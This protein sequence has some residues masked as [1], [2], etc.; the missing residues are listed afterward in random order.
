MKAANSPRSGST[1]PQPPNGDSNNEDSTLYQ[2]SSLAPPPAP[3]TRRNKTPNGE[4]I[5]PPRTK[6]GYENVEPR[7]TS[8][9]KPP[10]KSPPVARKPI[11]KRTVSSGMEASSSQSEDGLYENLKSGPPKPSPGAPPVPIPRRQVSNTLEPLEGSGGGNKR[12]SVSPPVPR[13]P[14]Q[15]AERASTPTNRPLPPE[16]PPK[17]PPEVPSREKTPRTTPD[18]SNRSSS[19]SNNN[20]EPPSD[21]LYSTV[22]VTQITDT[23]PDIMVVSGESGKKAPLEKVEK[24]LEKYNPPDKQQQLLNSS[25]NSKTSIAELVSLSNLL[26]LI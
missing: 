26:F 7:N 14:P 4:P 10:R 17:V 18:R 9:P 19:A 24:E 20:V 25:T 12:K 23:G 5:A 8:S 22:D 15:V 21:S 16:P 1:S 13:K 6:A 11:V 3:H 2:N